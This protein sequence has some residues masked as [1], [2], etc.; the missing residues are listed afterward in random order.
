MARVAVEAAA[1]G[2]WYKFVGLQGKVV[3]LD[4]FG[5]SAPAKDVYKD[6]HITVE[7]IVAVTKEVIY[8]AA[9]AVRQAV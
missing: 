4:R 8:S 1:T 3:G 7:N 6:C 5:A 2:G 9:C